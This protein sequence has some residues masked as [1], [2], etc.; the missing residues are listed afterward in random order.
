MEITNIEPKDSKNRYRDKN[1]FAPKWPFRLLCCGTSGSGKTV[2][3]FNLIKKYLIYDTIS[4]YSASLDQN[5]YQEFLEEM[6]R[7]AEENEDAIGK[8][9]FSDDLNRVVP[10][11]EMDKEEQNLVIFDDFMTTKNQSVIVEYFSKGRHNNCSVI[12]LSQSYYTTPKD[13]RLNCNY[14]ALFKGANASDLQHL[15]KEHSGSVDEKTFELLY[16]E[17]TSEPHGFLLVDKRAKEKALMFRYKFDGLF[18]G[19]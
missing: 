5:I 3:I 12:Y 14:F 13:I 6:E 8:F 16:K 10:V 1:F 17:A 4:I 18:T 9:H 2:M 7:L 19:W 11:K 15:R